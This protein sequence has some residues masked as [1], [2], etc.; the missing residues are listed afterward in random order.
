MPDALLAPSLDALYRV[1]GEFVDYRALSVRHLGT[2]YERLLQYRLVEDNGSLRLTESPGR[3]VSGSYF[4]PEKVVDVIVERTL[5]PLLKERSRSI[6]AQGLSGSDALDAFLDLRIV[7]PAMG[8]A[9]FLVGACAH[10]ALSIVTD[11]SYDGSL[12]LGDMQRLV[13]ERCLYG[14]DV[15][16]LAVELARLSLWLITAQEGE[17]LTF[18]HNL[19]EGNSLVGLDLGALLDGGDTVF[20]ARLAREAEALIEREREI[21]G[22]PRDVHAKERLARAV[23][24]LREPL[25]RYANDEL[26]PSFTEDIGRPFH[27]EL[28]FPEVFLGDDGRPRPDGG[29]DAV[30]GNPPWVRIQAL[31]RELAGYSRERFVT[32][33][34]SFDAYVLFLERGLR[35]LGP[36]GRLGF[37]VPNK[38]LKF[39]YARRLRGLFADSELVEEVIDFGD[40]QLFGEATNYSCILLLARGRAEELAYRRIRGERAAVERAL[41]DL[42][43]IAAEGFTT[44]DLGSEPWVL[45]SGVEAD[46]YKAARSRAAR[47]DEVAAGYSQASRR[48]PTRST[49]SRTAG[50]GGRTGS[51]THAR[52][53]A[54]S[55]SS[56]TFSIPSPAAVRWI[57]TL[58][59]RS[60]TCCSFPTGGM[61]RACAF[62]RRGSSSGSP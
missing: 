58:S 14:V 43:A 26:V 24:G 12:G 2:I 17:P 37:I 44:R 33:S 59:S 57:D 4:T 34:G 30:V 50:A 56:R 49:S 52:R 46:I 25:E 16:P 62:C 36:E 42:D 29:F 22:P 11:P 3:R 48:A 31:G 47:L 15:N 7:D 38:L 40:A 1:S 39:D 6:A 51:C 32:A 61:K 10:V 55:S 9:H 5:E 23:E 53:D 54:R 13:A 35:L 60:A 45:L 21:A 18:L 28:E 27:W 41:T 8:S 20:A 19:R